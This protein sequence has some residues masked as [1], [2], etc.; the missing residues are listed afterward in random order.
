MAVKGVE[1]AL[2]LTPSGMSSNPLSPYSNNQSQSHYVMQNKNRYNRQKWC[3]GVL[4]TSRSFWRITMYFR[5]NSSS[6][7]LNVV[8]TESPEGES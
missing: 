7:S 6:K 5:V 8:A 3:V 2:R 4:Q 1:G